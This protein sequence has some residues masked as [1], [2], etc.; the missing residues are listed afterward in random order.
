[1]NE[2]ILCKYGEIILKGANKATFE[3]LLLK[4]VRRRA[5]YVGGFSVRYNQ[6][7][8]YIEPTEENA[9]YQFAFHDEIRRQTKHHIETD[10]QLYVE[11]IPR[12]IR[13]M[14]ELTPYKKNSSERLNIYTSLSGEGYLSALGM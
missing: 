3:S 7:T 8:V 1:M 5:K 13:G 14:L 9:K 6:S 10:F 12:T 2:V 11:D 4:E